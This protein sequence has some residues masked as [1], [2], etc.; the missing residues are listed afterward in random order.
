MNSRFSNSKKESQF[1]TVTDF[2]SGD[3]LTGLKGGTNVNFPFS[4]LFNAMSGLTNMNQVGAPLGVPFLEQPAAG[5]NNIRNA[6]SSKGIIASVSAQNGVNFACNFSQAASG[7]TL[8][9][10]LNAAQ[11]QF[12][13]MVGGDNI[14]LTETVDSIVINFSPDV[15][16]N[17]TVIISAIGDFPDAVAGVRALVDDTDYLIV[18][19][20]TTSDR[21]T[22]SGNN[23]IRASASQMI[24]L[25][26][27]G[28]GTMFTM[29]NSSVKLDSITL[30]APTGKL[31]DHSNAA[32][33]GVFQM[34]E[35]NI[36]ECDEIGT[37]NN[38]F[39]T[40]IYATGWEDI[41]TDG[42]LFTG[43]HLNLDL[44]TS[45]I[46]LHGGAFIDLGT[47]VFN[48]IAIT[49]QAFQLTSSGTFISG[50]SGSANITS[51][52]LGAVS[53]CRTLGLVT[54]LAGVSTDDALWNF[55]INDD[56]QD[57]RPDG[58]LAFGTPTTTLLAPATPALITG[59]WS[60]VKI[61]QMAGT[62][63]GRLT[64]IGGKNAT[65]PITA[66]IS[67]ESV[68]GTN[69]A[70]NIYL[71]KNGSVITDSLVDTVVSSGSPKNQTVIWQDTFEPGSPGTFYELFIESVDGTDL[72]V[73]SAKL[74]V[75]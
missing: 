64:Y 40:R 31:F 39:I 8:I 57:T 45:V 20:I 23:T 37:F 38:M 34:V 11:Y 35:C 1:T 49:R 46:F 4:T 62:V 24:L 21:F 50:A 25:K 6:E 16:T 47:A 5:T 27:T 43:T 72:Q 55:I 7:A 22:I 61:S 2:V 3:L 66:T 60:V 73:N 71:A 44:D 33:T 48:A 68:S 65:I 14:A 18:N 58:L 15:A 26:Y 32:V 41:K 13:T 51:I 10:D 30:S 36:E 75:N 12:K 56:I 53:D 59:T 28:A 54:P 67:I 52:G 29:T 63:G 9:K 19:D 74:R 42:M 17:K 70:V 69:K